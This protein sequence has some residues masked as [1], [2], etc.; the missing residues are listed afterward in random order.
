[1]PD[2]KTHKILHDV[3]YPLPFAVVGYLFYAVTVPMTTSDLLTVF[4]IPVGYY[5]GSY[6]D[7]DLDL[8]TRTHA[9]NMWRRTR[10]FWPMN[11]WWR[12]YAVLA[13]FMG[14]HR[15][16]L[17]HAPFISTAI[18]F[19][20]FLFPGFMLAFALGLLRVEWM[21]LLLAWLLGV[22]IGLSLS[23]TV[24]TLFDLIL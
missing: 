15:S 14:G 10:I 23:D 22:Y 18:R 17:T 4:A 5:L 13:R 12:M 24:H 16:Y 6:I 8:P 3:F 1:M 21:G 2:G 9:E 19:V 20:W 11:I 7:P